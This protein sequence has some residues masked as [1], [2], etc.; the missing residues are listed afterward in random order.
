MWK[1]T[2]LQQLRQLSFYPTVVFISDDLTY[3]ATFAQWSLKGR[4][5]VWSTR[6]LVITR[7]PLQHLQ[8][9]YTTFSKMN[10]ML[11]II[12]DDDTASIRCNM[13]VHLPFTPRRTKPLWVAFWTPHRGLALT[14]SLPLFPDKFSRFSNRPNLLAASEGNPF[15]KM[16][17]TDDPE[18]P[19]GQRAQFKG[20]MGELMDFIARA[21]NFSYT[22]VR[23]PDRYWGNRLQNGSWSGMVGMVMRQEVNLAVGP[24][25]FLGERTGVVDFTVPAFIDYW[26]ILGARGRPEVDPWGFLFPLEPLVW[27]AILG[28][29]LVLPAALFLVASCFSQET[30]AQGIWLLRFFDYTRIL[31]QQDKN[32]MDHANWWWER[33]MLT[34]WGLVTVVLTQSYA[35]NLMAL[36]AVRHISEPYQTRQQVLDDPSTTMIWLKGSGLEDFLQ[37]QESGIYHK[38]AEA[39]KD[40]RLVWRPQQEFPEALNT[41]VRRGDHVLLDAGNSLISYFAQD[42]TKTGKCSFYSSREGFLPLILGMISSK[43]NP[44]IPALNNRITIAT[45][46]G[47]FFKWLM[48]SEPNSTI[49]LN[50][51][52]SITVKAPLSLSNVWGIFVILTVGYGSGLFILCLELMTIRIQDRCKNTN[53]CIL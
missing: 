44:I 24:F 31:L 42:F 45:E 52:T 10:A 51:P 29:L 48:D 32:I 38:M 15:H 11:L 22:N 5:L 43:D 25:M 20:P 49:C 1:L 33:V 3:L 14:T 9:H 18:A 12:D 19:G 46:A 26:R 13:Y 53:L 2:I 28:T 40:G 6:L 35:G 17:I 30:A 23:P 41:L 21:M 50:V 27:A 34:V 36:L 8:V 4:L 16:V 39:Q 37:S 7:L 47:L